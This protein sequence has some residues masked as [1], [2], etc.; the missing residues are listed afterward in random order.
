MRP[1]QLALPLFLVGLA[2]NGAVTAEPPLSWSRDTTYPLPTSPASAIPEGS[3]W[4]T[5]TAPTGRVAEDVAPPHALGQQSLFDSELL[6]GLPTG[7]RIQGALTRWENA[8]F[9][10]EGFAGFYVIVPLVGAG[11]RFSYTAWSGPHS[12]LVFRPGIDIYCA[13]NPLPGLG[14]DAAVGLLG[15][16]LECAWFHDFGQ[17]HCLELGLDLGAGF[18]NSTKSGVLPLASMFLGFCF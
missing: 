11:G 5:P 6:L 3:A 10:L 14:G 17:G 16:D 12:A 9:W 13:I 2:L 15:T 4:L 8:S 18:N 7:I 1:C